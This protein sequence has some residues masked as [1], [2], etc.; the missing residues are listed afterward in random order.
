MEGGKTLQLRRL[1]PPKGAKQ[2]RVTQTQ[3]DKR[4]KSLVAVPAWTPAM[5]LDRAPLLTNASIRNF[6]G[7]TAGYVADAAE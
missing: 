4:S 2:P 6:Q 7:G 3:V 1:C 5:I